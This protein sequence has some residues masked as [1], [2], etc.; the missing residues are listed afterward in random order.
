M[1]G[2]GIVLEAAHHFPAVSVWH[3]E[4]H[5][6]YVRVF[7]PRQ[8]ATLLAVLSRENL[9]IAEQLK[10]RL[11]HVQVVVVVFDVEHFGHVAYSIL[12]TAAL[13]TS[14]FDDLVGA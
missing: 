9:E 10:P 3:F 7:G 2:L 6:N 4:V 13:I 1:A 12:L 5:E 11:E 8:V 14:S